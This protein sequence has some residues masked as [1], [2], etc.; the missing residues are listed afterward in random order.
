MNTSYNA[1]VVKNYFNPLRSLRR[2]DKINLAAMLAKDIAE[3][4]ERKTKNKDV[5]NRFFGAFQSDK[6]AEEMIDEIRASRKFNRKIA[7]F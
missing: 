1:V 2:E 7:S 6:S 4:T 3:E 5:V